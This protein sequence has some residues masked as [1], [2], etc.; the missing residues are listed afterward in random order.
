MITYT[1][2]F[3]T[4]KDALIVEIKDTITRVING[5]SDAVEKL[6]LIDQEIE[7]TYTIKCS[8][9]FE[10]DNVY[11]EAG[12]AKF[13][14]IAEFNSC[15][16]VEEYGGVCDFEEQYGTSIEVYSDEGYLNIDKSEPTICVDKKTMGNKASKKRCN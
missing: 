1:E 10:P 13:N 6:K 15:D 16:C 3:H 12:Y 14:S 7:Y 5:D 8:C 4:D 9:D 11:A 2:K